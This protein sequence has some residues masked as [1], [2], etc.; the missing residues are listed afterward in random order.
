[1]IIVTLCSLVVAGACQHKYI[2]FAQVHLQNKR[3]RQ[4]SCA[5][6]WN[7]C[8]AFF[9]CLIFFLLG[10]ERLNFLFTRTRS[11][12]FEKR[13]PTIRRRKKYSKNTKI[14]IYGN[15]AKNLVGK[16]AKNVLILGEFLKAPK[17]QEKTTR[18]LSQKRL[19]KTFNIQKM[20]RF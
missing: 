9:F 18:V 16:N 1:M 13:T 17:I 7:V 12:V 6:Q 11:N 8:F 2:A 3:I 20:T 15:L 4:L 19:Q 5:F 14:A 10:K